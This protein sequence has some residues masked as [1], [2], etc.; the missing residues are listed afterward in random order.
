[1]SAVPIPGAGVEIAPVP[2][3]RLRRLLRDRRALAG[4]VLTTFVLVIALLGPLFA[5]HDPADII[6]TPFQEAGPGLPLG[7]DY[8]GE[9]VLSR[10]LSGGQRVV[11]MSLL[12][13]VLGVMLG[14][15]I[16]MVAGYARGR[17]DTVV[18]WLMD[19]VM[20]FP[21][22]VFVLLFVALLGRS[23]GLTVVLV[24]VGW[25]PTVG[26]LARAVT[27]EIVNNEFIE[28]A[29]MMGFN[30]RRILF[31]EILPNVITPLLVQA[32]ALL[33]WSIGIMAGLSFLGLG[34]QPPAAD[35]GLMTNENF[36]GLTVQPWAVTAPIALI[37]IFTIGINL[38]VE[39][40]NRAI[41]GVGEKA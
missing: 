7:A 32:G 29:E 23:P 14:A 2:P 20:A 24:A 36:A 33:T 27:L 28:S 40:V 13:T 25:A 4:V 22:L 26:R 30:R 9:D 10:V 37:A 21:L 15:T 19:V 12:A 1:M 31:R 11:W 38:I 3:R 16:G 39:S 18:V 8:L 6:G 5:P 34:V 41:A 35:W 17:L